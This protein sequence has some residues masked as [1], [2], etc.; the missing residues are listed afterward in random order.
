MSG[1]WRFALSR[2]WVGYLALTVVFAVACALL[3]NWQW[4]RNEQRL[5]E[6]ELVE[7]NYDAPP[8]DLADALAD[9]AAFDED[10]EWQPVLLRGRYLTE[11]QVVVR[12][13]PRSGSPGFEV[14][15]PFRTDDGE[16]FVV[17]R[18][19]VPVSGDDQNQPDAVPEAPTGDVEVVARLKP[20]EP[21]IAGRSAPDGQ[22]A[23]IH[24]PAFADR[25][26]GEVY[27]GAYGLL[28][29]EDPA[30]VERPLPNFKPEPDPGPHLSYTFQWF[31]FGLLAFIGL[32]WAVRQEYRARNADD[33]DEQRRAAERERRRSTKVDDA[34]V[35]DA[36]LDRR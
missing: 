19:W 36:L 33:P 20:G 7:R 23:T 21:E 11:E 10:E 16:V 9:P 4:S 29:S 35:E 12:N 17:D 1:G 31:I 3:G 13:R 30:P 25:I 8:V 18:G 2:R 28:V 14:L 22:L 24:L 15:V 32:G 27:T 34:D 26:P 5:A 6:I